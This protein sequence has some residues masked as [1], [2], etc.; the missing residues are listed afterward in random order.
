VKLLS[1][2]SYSAEYWY[3]I[4]MV[5]SDSVWIDCKKTLQ[6]LAKYKCLLR[7]LL[8]WDIKQCRLAAISL[9]VPSSRVVDHLTLEDGTNRLFKNISNQFPTYAA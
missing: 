2:Y 4:C 5:Q 9:L 1:P 7:P 3:R 6:L 8:F